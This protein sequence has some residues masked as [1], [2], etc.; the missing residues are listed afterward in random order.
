[1]AKK[2]NPPQIVMV[3]VEDLI[4]YVN[5]ARLH[6]EQ[7]VTNLAASIKEFGWTNPVLIDGENGLI[8]GHC[9]VLAAKKLKLKEIPAIE[10]A[11]LS[12]AQ[13]KAYILAD[14]KLALN[15]TWDNDLLR[16]ELEGLRA[17]G[18]D[19]ALTGFHADELVALSTLG[20]LE[21]EPQEP[22]DSPYTQKVQIPHYE[23]S[24]QC[25]EIS[26][27]L[28]RTKADQL[29]DTIRKAGLPKDVANFLLDAAERF[30]EFR[31]DRI[32]DFYAHSDEN[33]QALMEDSALVI[34]DFDK[35]IERG[36]VQL[37]EDTDQAFAQDYPDA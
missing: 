29:Q 22:G 1:M 25:P 8:A 37:L 27:L 36:F 15:G 12:E 26:D 14:N 24:D 17:D 11:H 9:R 16:V 20:D 31:F 32:A 23:P 28:D 6:S 4:P 7:D 19:L 33:I 13:K 5:N 34:I 21:A 2:A 10:L 18:F 30:V 3:P 35:A